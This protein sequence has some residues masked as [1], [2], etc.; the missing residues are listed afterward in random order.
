MYLYPVAIQI[1]SNL[2]ALFVIGI[3]SAFSG[4]GRDL[5][6]LIST[7]GFYIDLEKYHG[8]YKLLM[9]YSVIITIQ[10]IIT[11]INVRKYSAKYL[12]G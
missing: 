11:Y 4:L 9:I 6:S 1:W 7:P 2:S 5:F 8:D 10:L 12:R 3:I